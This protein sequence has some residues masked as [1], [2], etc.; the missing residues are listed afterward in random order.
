MSR[1][2][3]SV[4]LPSA[5]S[6]RGRLSR[7]SNARFS[8]IPS[9]CIVKLG[10]LHPTVPLV[11]RSPYHPGSHCYGERNRPLVREGRKFSDRSRPTQTRHTQPDATSS[12]LSAPAPPKVCV[13]FRSNPGLCGKNRRV[14][15]SNSLF[16]GE[17]FSPG[18][19]AS[20]PSRGRGPGPFRRTC[21]KFRRSALLVHF[22]NQASH[23]WTSPSRCRFNR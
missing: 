1:L 20:A 3:S 19:S 7:K 22:S 23:S 2:W 6:W 4:D 18:D 12:L 8:F 11:V 15:L 5:G 17:T 16:W 14:R 9:L 21:L 13:P 10:V